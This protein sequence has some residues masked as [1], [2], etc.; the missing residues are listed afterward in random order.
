MSLT[1]PQGQ[2]GCEFGWAATSSRPRARVSCKFAWA[3]SSLGPQVRLIS[4]P[5]AEP[6]ACSARA[7]V[8]GLTVCLCLSGGDNDKWRGYNPSTHCQTLHS[9]TNGEPEC[10]S[11]QE[12]RANPTTPQQTARGEKELAAQAKGLPAQVEEELPPCFHYEGEGSQ[13]GRALDKDTRSIR[14]HSRRG[15][16]LGSAGNPQRPRRRSR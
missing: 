10:P 5:V 11:P 7:F 6:G 14:T 4:A 16:P 15:R 12:P 9:G 3:A 13:Q 1:E 8:K 2:L